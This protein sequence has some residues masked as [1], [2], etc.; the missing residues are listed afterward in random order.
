MVA[1]FLPI[2][3]FR[4]NRVSCTHCYLAGRFRLL[5]VSEDCP[6]VL[7]KIWA[8]PVWSKV[9]ATAILTVAATVTTYLVGW[10][11]NIATNASKIGFL[12]AASTPVPNWLLVPICLLA[13]FGVFVPL[14]ILY[15]HIAGPDWHDYQQ[16]TFFGIVWRWRYARDTIITPVAF[17]P[18]CDTQMSPAL[19]LITP[20]IRIEL[21]ITAVIVITELL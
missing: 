10:W 7:K 20:T 21:F 5:G 9:I 11:P 4:M 8:D 18:R 2:L 13:A 15:R 1:V 16:D 6:T 3:I 12:A 19:T 17:C 14:A